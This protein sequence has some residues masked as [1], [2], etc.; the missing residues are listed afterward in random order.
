M[1]MEVSMLSLVCLLA[2][3]LL[4]FSVKDENKFGVLMAIIG[5]VY[6]H[7]TNESSSIATA[8]MAWR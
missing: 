8:A 3:S 6:Y 5:V 4:L 7:I 2:L 1:A